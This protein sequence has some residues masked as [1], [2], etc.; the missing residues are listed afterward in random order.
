[1]KEGDSLPGKM[2]PVLGR[3]LQGKLGWGLERWVEGGRAS[4]GMFRETD[5]LTEARQ[6]G[7]CIQGTCW[8]PVVKEFFCLW[9]SRTFL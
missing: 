7:E 1:M 4:A 9:D 2:L 8:F 3:G 6:V 5:G